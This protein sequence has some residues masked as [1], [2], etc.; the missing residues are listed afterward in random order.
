[1]DLISLFLTISKPNTDC[2]K[3]SSEK[4]SWCNNQI[5]NTPEQESNIHVHMYRKINKHR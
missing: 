5:F 2:E 4:L 3:K 1:M